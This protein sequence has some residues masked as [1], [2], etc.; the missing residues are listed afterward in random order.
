MSTVHADRHARSCEHTEVSMPNLIRP[1]RAAVRQ[2]AVA[3]VVAAAAWLVVEPLLRR[4]TGLPYG[5]ARLLG[6]LAT[7]DG[8]WRPLGTAA[9]LA[10]GAAFGATFAVLGRRGLRDG[11]VAAQLENLALWPFMAVV[12]RRH[13]DR[14]DGTWPPLLTDRRIIGHELVGHLVFG[15]VLGLLTTRPPRRVGW[16]D[17]SRMTGFTARV[18]R[19]HR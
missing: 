8:P 12:D 6:R 5:E 15:V 10:N 4:R 13:P 9:H 17:Q 2:G 18:G 7:A 19:V 11:I 1:H 3:G 14:R 16:T